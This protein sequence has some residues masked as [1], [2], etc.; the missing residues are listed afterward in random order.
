M[1]SQ[2]QVAGNRG[3]GVGGIVLIS[4][5][6]HLR[7]PA[8]MMACLDLVAISMASMTAAVG[9]PPMPSMVPVPDHVVRRPIGGRVSELAR[10]MTLLAQKNSARSGKDV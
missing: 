6:N 7:Y 3:D 8:A 2:P 9:L 5:R 1:R 10:I 4:I